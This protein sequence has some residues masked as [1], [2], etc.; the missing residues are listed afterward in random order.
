MYRAVCAIGRLP[1]L[2]DSA[3]SGCN[4]TAIGSAAPATVQHIRL[5]LPFYRACARY[6]PRNSPVITDTQATMLVASSTVWITCF[7]E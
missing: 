1:D 3:A 4:T 7:S 5:G 6:P 2:T